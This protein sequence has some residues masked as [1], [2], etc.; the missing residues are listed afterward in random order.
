[1]R[2]GRMSAAQE[3]GTPALTPARVWSP[4]QQAI[5]AAIENPAGGNLVIEAL[6][7][8]GKSTTIEECVKRTTE[9]ESVLVCAFNASIAAALKPRMPPDVHVST[10]HSFGF[11]ALS[12]ASPNRLEVNKFLT[13]DMAQQV[14]GRDYGTREARAAV[15]K[16][17]SIAK[18]Q[19][20]TWRRLDPLRTLDRWA[21]AYGIEFPR[22]WD[23][24][25]LCSVAL[26]ILRAC[27]EQPGSQCDFDDMIWLPVVRDLEIPRFDWV[28][29]DETQDLN[30]AQLEIVKRAGEGGRI[31]AVGDRRQA[32][33]GFRG[34]DREAIP[35]M[36]KELG[37]TT[38]PLSVTYR[39]PKLVVAEA[40]ELV[41]EL[42]AAP[43]AP[44]GIVRT[45]GPDALERDAAPGD[46]VLSRIN[47]PLV[48]LAF[49]WLAQGRRAAIQGRDIGSGLS[50]WIKASGVGTG[51]GSVVRLQR[52]IQEWRTAEIAR[53]EAAERDTQ[54]CEDKAACLEA[55]CSG[56]DDVAAVLA[57]IESLFSDDAGSGAILLSSTHRAK[58]LEAPRVW[59]LRDTYCKRPG[60]EEENLLYVAITRSKGELVYVTEEPHP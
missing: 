29:V 21:D 37:A 58:G 33:Y 53:L 32:I 7:G 3:I 5:F 34:A 20:F 13:A 49:R 50:A 56:R 31:T 55:L 30:P 28:F 35:R 18:G 6:A 4:M 40:N 48:S 22:S 12:E 17:V 19:A 39:C 11:R 26:Q 54:A 15:C 8:T 2:G 52:K 24:M 25:R 41:P 45:C 36:I 9:G 51:F 38:L 43:S 14:L 59:L 10:I 57:R 44:E 42:E 23:R 1:M 27:Q 16:L 60:P 47:A 46:M